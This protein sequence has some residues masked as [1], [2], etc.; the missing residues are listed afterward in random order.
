MQSQAIVCVLFG[1]QVLFV[2]R[3][4]PDCWEL[5]GECY[6]HG[7]MDGEAVKD[8]DAKVQRFELI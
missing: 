5:V 8:S 2:L 7:F 4:G 6:I 3:G 1:G